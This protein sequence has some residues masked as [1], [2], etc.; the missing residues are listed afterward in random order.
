MVKTYDLAYGGATV[1]STLAK[2]YLP[3]VLSLQQQVQQEFIPLYTGAD[4]QAYWDPE[5]TL[6]AFWFGINDVGN[7]Y[8]SSLPEEYMAV[9]PR[10]LDRYAE[11]IA[12]LFDMGARN[13][14]FLNIPPVQRS[15]LTQSQGYDASVLEF[16]AIAIF[17]NGLA[18]MA[19]ELRQNASLVGEVVNVDVF[20]AYSLFSAVLDDPQAFEI[21]K[22]YVNTTDY[23]AA[24]ENG[25]FTMTSFDSSCVAPV[26]DYFWL[27]SLHPT[28]PMH[29]LLASSIAESV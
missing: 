18:N 14:L 21:T 28:Y 17:N 3:T 13:F 26:N 6:F 7:T 27:N 1:D 20:D 5:S 19:E 10:I 24:Y 9:Y 23:C 15:P 25:T 8:S 22:Q 16:Q 29:D 2:P 11:Q 4:S 12:N